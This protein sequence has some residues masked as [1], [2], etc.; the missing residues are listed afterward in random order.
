MS[1]LT[2]VFQNL[3]GLN[4]DQSHFGEFGSFR[5]GSPV[6]T[7]DP[8]SIQSLSAFI[9]NGWL[10]AVN[11]SN[12]APFLEEM[13]GVHLLLFRQLAYLFQEGT[14]EWDPATPYFVGSIV[15]KTGTFELYGSVVDNNIGNAL[16]SQNNNGFWQYLNPPPTPPGTIFDYAGLY[17]PSGFLVCDGTSYSTATYPNLFA[18]IG[19]VWG[20]GGGNFNVPDMRT[21]VGVGSG[22][23]G[24]S[25][26]LNVGDT[27]GEAT[28]TLVT[29]EIPVHSHSITDVPHAHTGV[30]RPGGQAFSGPITPFA[31]SD[32]PHQTDSSY[33]G[34]TG[35]NNTGGNGA[36]NNVQPC[37]GVLKIIKY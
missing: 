7:K 27:G 9:T 12:K 21:R 4:G 14:P 32:P 6:T 3:F 30:I 11:S 1:K 26:H 31:T 29:S 25:F 24:G 20:G 8:A 35:T 19:Y 33:T 2:R 17:L 23:P 22:N 10:D 28:H 16:P 5:A 15:K 34:I 18:A 37:A 13:N 36:H